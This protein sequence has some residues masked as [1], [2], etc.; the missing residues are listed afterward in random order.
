MHWLI[1][2]LI[3]RLLDMYMRKMKKFQNFV[4]LSETQTIATKMSSLHQTAEKHIKKCHNAN[5]KLY[6]VHYKS[7][8]CELCITDNY[9]G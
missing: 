3:D 8:Y 2:W 9:L 7:V 4:P 5:R 1:D 6:N